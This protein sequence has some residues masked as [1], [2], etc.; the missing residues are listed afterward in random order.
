MSCILR[1]AEL[2]VIRFLHTVLAIS[3]TELKIKANP[4]EET[5]MIYSL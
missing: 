2:E 4:P 1:I 5:K 3:L